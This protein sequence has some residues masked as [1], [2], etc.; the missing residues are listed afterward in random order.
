RSHSARPRRNGWRSSWRSTWRRLTAAESR[1]AGWYRDTSRGCADARLGTKSAKRI[2]SAEVRSRSATRRER[3]RET[4]AVLANLPWDEEAGRNKTER[5]GSS[6]APR[7]VG[8]SVEDD[9]R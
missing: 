6:G 7:G 8:R 9:G 3:S 2:L 5:V 1:C 4:E